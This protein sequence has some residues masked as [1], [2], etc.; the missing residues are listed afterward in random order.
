MPHVNKKKLARERTFFQ[1]PFPHCTLKLE[2][3]NFMPQN[4]S[5]FRSITY[6]GGTKN[7]F[8]K[9]ALNLTRKIMKM[10]EYNLEKT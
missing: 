7:N 3:K 1:T 5:L 4:H 9:N 10:N 2:R 8:T 6:F